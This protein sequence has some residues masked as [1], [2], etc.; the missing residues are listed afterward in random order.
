MRDRCSV[1]DSHRFETTQSGKRRSLTMSGIRISLGF[2]SPAQIQD[3]MRRDEAPRATLSARVTARLHAGKFD[4]MLAVGV[5]APAGSALAIHAARL[6]SVGEREAIART[7]RRSLDDA[8]GRTAA[9]VL[10]G[11]AARAQ[12][13]GRRGSHRPGHPAVALAAS[14][15]GARHRATA[16]ASRRRLRADVPL[17]PRRTWRAGWARRSPNC[18][19]ARYTRS[20]AAPEIR[21][22]LRSV[23]ASSARPSGYSGVVT[24]IR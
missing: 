8:R 14:G 15:H 2:L 5:P 1:F 3:A 7:L 20:T 18:R 23:K 19:P 21:P 4:R 6:T 13:H 24:A 9:D 22:A 17:R 11:A 12:H 10:S 16:G